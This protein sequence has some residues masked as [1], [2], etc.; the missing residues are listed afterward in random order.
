[1]SHGAEVQLES[2]PFQLKDA[3][4]RSTEE[5]WIGALLVSQNYWRWRSMPVMP[6][7]E[8][9]LVTNHTTMLD[10]ELVVLQFE[11]RCD[12]SS[13]LTVDLLVHGRPS[14]VKGAEQAN[15]LSH[16]KLS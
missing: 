7:S 11:S 6:E 13:D 12:R 8:I 3:S 2:I 5:Q 14:S 10:L 15:W 1:V 4:T 16:T 9:T